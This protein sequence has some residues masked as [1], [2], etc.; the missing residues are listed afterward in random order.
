M[1][2]LGS[3]IEVVSEQ[4]QFARSLVEFLIKVI[5]L[6]QVSA[7]IL[8]TSWSFFQNQDGFSDG[9]MWLGVNSEYLTQIHRIQLR[10]LCIYTMSLRVV[11]I[12]NIMDLDIF[13]AIFQQLI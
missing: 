10:S 6:G 9:L 8:K 12:Y 1:E 7:Y 5:T 3:R 4:H 2:T 11:I 13:H